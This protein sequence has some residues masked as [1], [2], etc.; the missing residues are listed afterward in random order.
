MPDYIT[1]SVCIAF[2]ARDFSKF[3]NLLKNYTEPKQYKNVSEIFD[4]AFSKLILEIRTY[5]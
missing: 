3:V 2:S 4:T 1:L 5:V